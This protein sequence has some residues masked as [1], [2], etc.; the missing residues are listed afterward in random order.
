MPHVNCVFVQYCTYIQYALAYDMAP[1]KF[2]AVKNSDTALLHVRN[3]WYLRNTSVK[4]PDTVH[5]YSTFKRLVVF[6]PQVFQLY[7]ML[8]IYHTFPA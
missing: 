3:M 4:N 1:V 6:M 8:Q 5:P 2:I 7:N